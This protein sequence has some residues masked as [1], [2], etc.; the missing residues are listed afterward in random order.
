[1]FILSVVMSVTT[2]TLVY[3]T[4][5]NGATLNIYDGENETEIL[6]VY[7]AF[8]ILLFCM[9]VV[10]TALVIYRL[11]QKGTSRDLK[12]KVC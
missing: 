7:R 5:K 4:V 6:F 9:S 8:E 2:A 11:S 3:G 10:P 1:M 12:K